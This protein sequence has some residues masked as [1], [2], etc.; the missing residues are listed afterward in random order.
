MTLEDAVE[1]VKQAG[2][3]AI[4]RKLPS[5]TLLPLCDAVVTGG[6]RAVEVTVESEGAFESIRAIRQQYGDTLLIGAGTVMSVDDVHQAVE[7]GADLLLSPHLDPALVAAAHA[8]GRPFVP[9]VATPSEVVQASRAGARVLK[10]F[11]AAPLGASYLKDLLG[12]FHDKCFL[13][14]GGITVD[15][16]AEFIRAGAVGVGMG[17]SLAAK[18]EMEAA[19]WASIRARAAQVL[20]RVQAA[21]A[22]KQ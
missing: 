9:G 4:F 14:T 19:D 15:N 11:P 5:A 8:L 20:E 13:P 10:L 3:I 21:K 1:R 6:I 7:A 16:A 2:V 18:A 22:A 12:P 17:S